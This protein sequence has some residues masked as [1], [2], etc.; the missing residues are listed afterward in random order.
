MRI[1]HF[2]I[3]FLSFQSLYSQDAQDVSLMSF[4]AKDIRERGIHDIGDIATIVPNLF[5]TSCGSAQ[6]TAI[7]LRGVGSCANTPAV[8][9]YVDDMP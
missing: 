2:I 7:Y 1:A 8:G 5:V 9:M 4:D 6:N 3:A